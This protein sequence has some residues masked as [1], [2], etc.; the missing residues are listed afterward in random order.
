ML[1]EVITRKRDTIG[2]QIRLGI[3]G[4]IPLKLKTSKVYLAGAGPGDEELVTIK[5]INVLKQ[6][7]VVVYDYL[8]NNQLLSY[9][10]PGCEKIY[11][12]KKSG[13]V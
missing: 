1:Y 5:T 2:L 12:G 7:D 8:A 3:T 9:C 6:A 13:V 10:K 4:S 11:V